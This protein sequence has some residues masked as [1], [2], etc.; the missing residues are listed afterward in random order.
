MLNSLLDALP[1]PVERFALGAFGSL[2]LVD[3]PRIADD[4]LKVWA[5][6]SKTATMD[7]TLAV[8]EGGINVVLHK[9][10]ALAHA[11]S[12]DT[13][14]WGPFFASYTASVALAGGMATLE[15]APANKLDLAG[16]NVS[17]AITGSIGSDLGRILPPIC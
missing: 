5:N 10:I 4:Q 9:A 13:E 8:S 15:N 2:G 6:I 3:G 14:N 16:V 11:S 7:A 12:H 17:G 1:Y